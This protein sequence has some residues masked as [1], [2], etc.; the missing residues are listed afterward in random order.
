[1]QI[2]PAFAGKKSK[3]LATASGSLPEL[4]DR[5]GKL[6]DRIRSLQDEAAAVRN[7]I[8]SRLRVTG[9]T[10]AQGQHYKLSLETPPDAPPALS[11]Q[12]LSEEPKPS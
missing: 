7:D 12:P 1:M 8:A 4:T 10:E 3:L 9:Q 11:V 2:C 6:A 5:Y